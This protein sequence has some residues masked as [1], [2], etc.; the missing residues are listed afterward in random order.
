M[1]PYSSSIVSLPKPWHRIIDL[2]RCFVTPFLR[3]SQKCFHTPS[4]VMSTAVRRG[5]KHLSKS[6][7][8]FIKPS[9]FYILKQDSICFSLLWRSRNVHSTLH[10]R[11]GLSLNLH[12][13][14]NVSFK[15]DKSERK[16]NHSSLQDRAE[17]ASSQSKQRT[18]MRDVMKVTL[19]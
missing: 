18:N 15:L 16:T 8:D 5:W 19:V 2:K 10:Q 14:T 13:W 6:V 9:Y 1:S 7:C 11:V 17:Y 4:E 3:W 12:F